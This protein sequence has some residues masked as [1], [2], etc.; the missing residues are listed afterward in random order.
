M[1]KDTM[2]KVEEMLKKSGR[3][4]LSM[5]ELDQVSGGTYAQDDFPAGGNFGGMLT[6]CK[7]KSG[8]L[9]FYFTPN[10]YTDELGM[11]ITEDQ[12]HDIY[13]MLREAFPGMECENNTHQ[14]VWA[15]YV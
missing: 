13:Y 9:R 7:D 12:Y 2:A 1:D 4:E 14:L 11:E 6:A 3:R 5:D 15:M 8:V 10:A